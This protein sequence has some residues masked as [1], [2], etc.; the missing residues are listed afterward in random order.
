MTRPKI[1]VISAFFA[2]M[3]G[4]NKQGHCEKPFQD[5]VLLWNPLEKPKIK[6]VCLLDDSISGTQD[7]KIWP[8]YS[9]AFMRSST[10]GK[11]LS[12][13]SA[14]CFFFQPMPN[15]ECIPNLECLCREHKE[16]RT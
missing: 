15:F 2:L 8:V 6:Y 5:S 10:S 4:L 14:L 13:G 16:V 7:P 11:I 1:A 3:L 12:S 9:L